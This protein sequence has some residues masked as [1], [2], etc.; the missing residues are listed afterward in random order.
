MLC[1]FSAWANQTENQQ[2]VF[3][4][5]SK[6]SCCFPSV[7]PQQETKNWILS[8]LIRSDGNTTCA[9]VDILLSVHIS[10]IHRGT[11][12]SFLGTIR[13]FHLNSI[14]KGDRERERGRKTDTYIF[15]N[16]VLKIFCP[17]AWM[18]AWLGIKYRKKCNLI[19]NLDILLVQLLHK[20]HCLWIQY[21]EQLPSTTRLIMQ[22]LSEVNKLS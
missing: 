9:L 5:N 8:S 15:F 13:N 1:F 16:A 3:M 11:G 17:S 4:V 6:S 7:K 14:I 19:I 2:A 10:C 12:Q 18:D 22:T 20:D 21:M